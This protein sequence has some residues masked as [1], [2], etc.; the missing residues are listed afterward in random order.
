[1]A[2]PET[3]PPVPAELVRR[4]R[5]ATDLPWVEC[6]RVLAPLT[7]AERLRYV[8]GFETRPGRTILHDPIEDDPA[9][10]PL[11][12]AARVDAAREVAEW[13]RQYVVE[14]EARSPAVA[15]MLRSGRGLC[16]RVWGRTKELMR[17]RHGIDWRSPRE[18]NPDVTFD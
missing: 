3:P 7:P 18:M 15:D 16:H 8:E 14:M 5:V 13:H 4:L 17:E 12:L 6:K 9:V 10:R 1:M 11:F 2:A